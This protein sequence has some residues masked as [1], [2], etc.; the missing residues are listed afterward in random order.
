VEPLEARDNLILDT[1]LPWQPPE[2]S[3]H[4][5]ARLEPKLQPPHH[6]HAHHELNG[7]LVHQSPGRRAEHSSS[8]N[9]GR[10]ARPEGPLHS[11]QRPAFDIQY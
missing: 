10:L 6:S 5:A 11:P 1:N 3:G 8:Q 2:L 9:L 7:R 4:P